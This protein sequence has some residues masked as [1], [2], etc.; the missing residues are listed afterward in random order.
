M[1]KFPKNI[2]NNPFLKGQLAS[3]KQLFGENNRYAVAPVHTRFSNVE[4]FVWD[5][6]HKLSTLNKAEV[7]RQSE[8]FNE[9]IKGLI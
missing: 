8:N 4:W 1:V 9:A 2:K 6:E 7:I 3:K 5:A